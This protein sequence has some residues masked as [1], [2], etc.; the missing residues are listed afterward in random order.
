MPARHHYFSIML[1]TVIH[2]C[3]QPQRCSRGHP[4]K[5]RGVVCQERLRTLSL[6]P[7]HALSLSPLHAPSLSRSWAPSPSPSHIQPKLDDIDND[8]EESDT[9]APELWDPHAGLK[10]LVFDGLVSVANMEMD[11][12]LPTGGEEEVRASMVEM[13]V[14]LEQHDDGEWL[15]PRLRKRT[16]RKTGMISSV[17]R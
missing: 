1:Q 11:V 15:P 16:T 4:R 3:M 9:G 10:T 8:S 2:P 13:M 6:S 5:R 17:G 12:D 7:S 14:D